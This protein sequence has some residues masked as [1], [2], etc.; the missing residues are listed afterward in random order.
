VSGS[1]IRHLQR[2]CVGPN[3]VRS[4]QTWAEASS[5]SAWP[6]PAQAA[7]AVSVLFIAYQTSEISIF[8][9]GFAK[10]ERDN[11]SADELK[12]L[13]KAARF[14]FGL[15]GEDLKTAVNAGRLKEIRD[16]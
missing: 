14:Y 1:T 3:A 13:R 5:S 7:R 10:N 11:I 8:L 6:A 15:T 4:T 2:L 9:Y 16:A 12:D